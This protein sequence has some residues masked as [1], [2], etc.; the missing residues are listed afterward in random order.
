MSPICSWFGE[1][2]DGGNRKGDDVDGLS[3][4]LLSVWVEVVRE[5]DAI[6]G[7]AAAAADTA[8]DIVVVA[9]KRWAFTEIGNI[10]GFGRVLRPIS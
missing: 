9:R 1:S 6:V 2:G 7:A 10:F 3:V 4:P 8:A 5:S